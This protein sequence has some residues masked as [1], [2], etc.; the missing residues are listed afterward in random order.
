VVAADEQP[1]RQ[2]RSV[3]HPELRPHHLAALDRQLVPEHEQLDVFHVQ[4]APATNERAQQSPDGE[5]EEGES[6]AADPLNPLAPS[7]RHRYWRPSGLFFAIGDIS[8]KLVTQGGE[9]IG[10][11][12]TVVGGYVLGTW[13]LQLGY[14]VGGAL[15]V[16]GVATLL[17]NA[18]PIAAG[19]IVL[20]EPVPAGAF[21]WI[22]L[23]AFGAV[24]VGAILLTRPDERNR[25]Q[26]TTTT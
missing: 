13:L 8:T 15:T 23:L 24:V 7:L 16:A 11:V 26:A 4:A 17:T 10:F 3:S 18:V 2:Q 9:R 12:V 14:Q 22:R 25:P 21:G 19:T 5:I 20:D 6:H 1:Q